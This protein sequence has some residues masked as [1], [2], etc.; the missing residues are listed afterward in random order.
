MKQILHIFRKDLRHH[1]PEMTA[2]LALLIAYNWSQPR[3][4]VPPDLTASRLLS[5]VSNMLPVL[6]V[7]SWVFFIVRIV[8]DEGLVGDRQFWVTRPY[9]WWRLL[10]E[11]VLLTI[12]VV[13]IPLLLA[14]LV[15]LRVAGFHVTPAML[16]PLA[17]DHLPLVLLVLLPIAALAAV[18][19][20][21]VQ[22]LLALLVS[23]VYIAGAAALPLIITSQG[24]AE[25]GPR[26]LSTLVVGSL[27][28]VLCQYSMR[29]TFAARLIIG[30]VA[31]IILLFIVLL[32]YPP[33]V[34]RDYPAWNGPAP[35]KLALNSPQRQ[36]MPPNL[37]ESQKSVQIEIPFSLSGIAEG[38]LASVQGFR[39]SV[40]SPYGARWTSG[41]KPYSQSLF[42]SSSH[43]A[44][45]FEVPREFFD[46]IK[47][48]NVTA[49]L[50]LALKQ[51]QEARQE[52]IIAA[53]HE[54][55]V[56]AVGI[57]SLEPMISEGLLCRF[58]VRVPK[59]VLVKAIFSEST[60]PEDQDQASV[61]PVTYGVNG[62]TEGGAFSAVGTFHLFLV[63][64]DRTISVLPKRR[65]EASVCPG[66]PL[67]FS[68]PRETQQNTLTLD[69][70]D[71]PMADYF[72][73]PRISYW[74]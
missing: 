19:A 49:R 15:M 26:E 37:P 31:V 17:Y 73:D 5:D 54:F 36:A 11:K 59:L 10:I 65:K 41:W 40:T 25:V 9:S 43:L 53:A 18:T 6:L 60:C 2:S 7:I 74:R 48:G 46:R 66:T 67:S 69:L 68:F 45:F 70:Q 27:A 16:S 42:P 61:P 22:M 4:W 28:V 30:A 71:F 57:C 55:T 29:R 39:I 23:G 63:S 1:W 44:L 56:P 50:D 20:S 38:S 32:P 8:Q 34:A 24:S 62:S 13:N 3:N 12:L 35:L 14:N 58:P 51:F 52:R 72:Y 33:F 47:S 64:P 21:L